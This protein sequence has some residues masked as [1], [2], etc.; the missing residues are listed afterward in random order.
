[1]MV[2]LIIATWIG[3]GIVATMIYYGLM[4]ITPSLFLVTIC[5]LCCIVSLAI[6]SSWS[7]MGTVGV[8]GMGIAVSMGIP[9]PMAAGAIISGAYFGDK[10]SPLSDTTNLASGLSGS[11]LFEHIRHMLY[12]T[13]PGL[14]AALIA[15]WIMG[16]QFTSDTV[17]LNDIQTVMGALQNNFLISPGL[18]LVR[19]CH[20]THCE[21]S[22]GN[23]GTCCWH[24]VGVFMP[25]CRTGRF[26]GR[27]SRCVAVRLCD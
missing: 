5:I 8:A 10:M 7:T 2:G 19:R 20:C 12:T 23:S 9:L 14:T 26:G 25:H 21:E 11:D 18:L 3:G 24:F 16:M 22:P 1:M 15:Y 6:G 13:I 17:N 27:C 4:L